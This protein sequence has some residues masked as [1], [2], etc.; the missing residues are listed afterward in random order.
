MLNYLVRLCDK[1]GIDPLDAAYRKLKLNA[2]KYPVHKAKGNARKYTEF[3][4]R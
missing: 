3:R 4:D 2:R 1:L